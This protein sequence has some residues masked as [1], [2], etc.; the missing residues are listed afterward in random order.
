MQ[1]KIEPQ[2]NLYRWVKNYKRLQDTYWNGEFKLR[3][4]QQI[5]DFVTLNNYQH[6]YHD[7]EV[8]LD[9]EIPTVE[10]ISDAD[11]VLITHQGYSRYPLSGIVEMIEQW[12]SGADLYLC[13]NRHY[14]NI[15]NQ[16]IDMELPDDFQQAITSWLVQSLPNHTVVDMSR[17]YV[18]IGNHFSWSCP[19]RHYYIKAN[20]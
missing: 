12:T 17:N 8:L 13:L 9:L 16:K 5:E 18:D 6:V 11:L 2:K 20:K 10:Q 19:D 7:E 1:I 4:L 3:R 14:I 15:D